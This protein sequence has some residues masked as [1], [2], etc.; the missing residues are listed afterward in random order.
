VVVG[1]V[2]CMAVFGSALFSVLNQPVVGH[3]RRNRLTSAMLL[4]LSAAIL[5]AGITYAV[6]SQL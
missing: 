3:P 4:S 6:T 2:A 5:V 1:V